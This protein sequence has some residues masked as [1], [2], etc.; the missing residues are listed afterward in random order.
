[1]LIP[2]LREK[3]SVTRT[4]E[5]SKKTKKLHLQG[6]IDVHNAIAEVNEENNNAVRK[7]K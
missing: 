6:L 3:V 7:V 2:W 4:I 5:L 1:M